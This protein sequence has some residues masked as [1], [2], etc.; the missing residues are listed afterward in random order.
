LSKSPIHVKAHLNAI[1][2][3]LTGT[4]RVTATTFHD[5][6]DVAKNTD[7]T[8]A[9]CHQNLRPGVLYAKVATLPITKAVPFIK[10]LITDH[11]VVNISYLL[12]NFIQTSLNPP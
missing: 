2:V 11:L 4:L 12:P 8:Y 6:S 9:L 1:V 3:C 10:N 5:A 7:L